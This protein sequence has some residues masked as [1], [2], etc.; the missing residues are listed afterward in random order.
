M[1]TGK[2]YREYSFEELKLLLAEA[3]QRKGINVLGF[4]RSL[5]ENRLLSKEE[6]IELRDDAHVYF[7]KQFDFLQLKDP[8]TFLKI[9]LLGEEFTEADEHQLWRNIKRN[10]QAILKE[11]RIRHR[12]F[13][14]YS[15][16]DCGYGWCRYNGMMIRQGSEIAEGYMHFDSDKPRH[17]KQQKSLRYRAERKRFNPDNEL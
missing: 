15:I 17:N 7:Q 2:P 6:A 3:R 9:T 1:Q 12:N 4:Y 11:K 10:Q 8:D 5:L 14:V 13:G 16:H